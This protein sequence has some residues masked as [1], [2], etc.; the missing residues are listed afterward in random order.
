MNRGRTTPFRIP[1]RLLDD[2]RQAGLQLSLPANMRFPWRGQPA[3]TLTMFKP[4]WF[5]LHDVQIHLGKCWLAMGTRPESAVG[6]SV[7][8]GNHI[9][10][11][12]V[13]SHWARVTVAEQASRTASDVDPGHD[14]A[15]DHIREWPGSQRSFTLFD[16]PQWAVAVEITLSFTSDSLN[17]ASTY[18]VN[19]SIKRWHRATGRVLFQSKKC[20]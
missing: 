15:T 17:P 9:D 11:D 2:L 13:A 20:D 5:G 14:C 19:I 6:H 16:S 7:C 8:L 12:A 1:Q 10:P 3:A 4:H 18:V